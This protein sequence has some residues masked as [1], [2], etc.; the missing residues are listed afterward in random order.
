MQMAFASI[1]AC[2]RCSHKNSGKHHGLPTPILMIQLN[3][4]Y[5]LF[6]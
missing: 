6:R 1:E 2:A 4:E 5:F 3:P